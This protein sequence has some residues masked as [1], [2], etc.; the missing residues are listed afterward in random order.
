MTNTHDSII[1]GGFC[2]SKRYGPNTGP[3]NKFHEHDK[4]GLSPYFCLGSLISMM[5]DH[6]D[7]AKKFIRSKRFCESF[8]K[9]L[10]GTFYVP[11]IS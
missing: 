1:F 4:F 9:Y 6:R 8:Y 5:K 11:I 10:L 2:D 7:K 3:C